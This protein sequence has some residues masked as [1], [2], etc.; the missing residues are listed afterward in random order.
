MVKAKKAE[1]LIAKSNYEKQLCE[2]T[3][4]KTKNDHG[5]LAHLLITRTR[6]SS[7]SGPPSRFEYESPYDLHDMACLNLDCSL[8]NMGECE[9]ASAISEDFCAY[10]E[11]NAIALMARAEAKLE[12]DLSSGPE[13]LEFSEEESNPITLKSSSATERKV[14]RAVM[15]SGASDHFINDLHMFADYKKQPAVPIETA[16]GVIYGTGRGHVPVETPLG[17]AYLKN[18]IHCRDLNENLLFQ[19]WISVAIV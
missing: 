14:L 12:E 1:V 5:H 17:N 19:P 2:L 3:K 18:V 6:L 15:D 11:S 16:G 8:H 7:D 4:L 13:F 9:F 10:T